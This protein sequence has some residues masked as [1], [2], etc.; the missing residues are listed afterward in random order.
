M[1]PASV[2]V[3]MLV[4]PSKNVTVSVLVPAAGA[5]G[6]TVAVNVTDWPNVEGFRFDVTVVVVP[7]LLTVCVIAGLVLV[8]KVLS[9]EYTAV[10]L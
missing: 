8:A 7:A 10:I 5:T 2:P 3:P 4:A 9:P 1:P 6:D